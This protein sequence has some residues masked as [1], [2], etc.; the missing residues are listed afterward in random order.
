M[1]RTLI[2]IPKMFSEKELKNRRVAIPSDLGEKSSEF[3]GYVEDRLKVLSTRIKRVYVESA[4]RGG[5][6]N[7]NK[8]RETDEKLHQVLGWLLDQGAEITATEDILLILEAESWSDLAQQ[9]AGGAEGEMLEDSLRDRCIF[10]SK[11]VSETLKEGET[12]VLFVDTLRELNF[13]AD[14]RVIRMMPFDPKDYLKAW[15]ISS[16]LQEKREKS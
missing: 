3:W 11:R 9:G 14:I 1:S 8:I 4:Y 6:D 2:L 16:R 13:D 5:I 12:G 15:L 10:V 7:L